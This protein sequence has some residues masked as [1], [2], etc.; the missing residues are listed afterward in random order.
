VAPIAYDHPEAVAS[1]GMGVTSFETYVAPHIRAIRVGRMVLYPVRELAQR[2]AGLL[3]GEFGLPPRQ[4]TLSEVAAQFGVSR[5]WV[6]QHADEL[7][8]VRLGT[9]PRARLQLDAYRVA[10]AIASRASTGMSRLVARAT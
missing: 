7:G 3:R 1:F 2:V 10:T 5:T 9:G 8:A 4:L 6:Y